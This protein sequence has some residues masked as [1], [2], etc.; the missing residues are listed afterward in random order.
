MFEVFEKNYALTD[1]ALREAK[2]G[3]DCPDIVQELFTTYG[4]ATFNHGLY[5]IHDATSSAVA[6]QAARYA[7]GNLGIPLTCF[8]FDWLGRQF[9]L[10][11]RRGTADDPEVL[12]LEPGTGEAFEVPVPFSAFH[13]HELIEYRDDCL[14]PA[15]FA[16]WRTEVDDRDL[17]FDSCVG[18]KTPLFLGG[19]DET[20][21]LELID[22][23]VYWAFAGQMLVATRD[24]P[25]GTR[26]SGVG[27][28]RDSPPRSAL[29][30]QILDRVAG[31]AHFLPG[32]KRRETS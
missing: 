7:Y 18:Y 29:G 9:A 5:R 4:R 28:I 20:S 17:A 24:L 27:L 30:R 22:T 16:V 26:I 23:E 10:D 3:A 11:P 14:A 1:R 31:L 32:V 25:D 21:N 12:L 6:T 15:Y 2:D 19:L 13:D 8:G